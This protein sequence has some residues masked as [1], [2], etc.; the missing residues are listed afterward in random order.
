MR[1]TPYLT[2]ARIRV[3]GH[4][5]FQPKQQN[6]QNHL[7]WRNEDPESTGYGCESSWIQAITSPVL[8]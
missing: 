8:P 6:R 5:L 1:V 4:R 7:A 2:F 3:H